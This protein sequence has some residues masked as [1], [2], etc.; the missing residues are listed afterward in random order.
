[1]EQVSEPTRTGYHFKGWQI[2]EEPDG[3]VWDFD[4][5]VEYNTG[6]L[7]TT[8]YAKWAD[9]LAPILGEAAFTEGS[10]NFLDWLLQKESMV[11]TVPVTEEGSGL[12]KA[13]YLLLAEDGS[14]KEGEARLD[15]ARSISPVA[16]AYGSGAT[17]LRRAGLLLRKMRRKS[18][19]LIPKNLPEESP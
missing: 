12:A 6:T 14:E 2:G 1:M 3:D 7:H 19:F 16:A 13:E 8:L 18:I 4:S 9:E 5:P 11:I 15:E 17:V 10:R